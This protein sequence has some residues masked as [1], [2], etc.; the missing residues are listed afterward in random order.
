MKFVAAITVI[1]LTLMMYILSGTLTRSEGTR[2]ELPTGGTEG[3]NTELVAL[4]IMHGHETLAFFDDARYVIDEK[5]QLKE[6]ENQLKERSR[7]KSESV[8]LVMADKKVPTGAL[9]A[10][11]EAAK[12]A[13]MKE[14]L[15]ANRRE[16]LETAE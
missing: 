7:Q 5:T 9:I 3:V 15:V 13:G 1:L 12:R 10:F 8:L 11:T 14:V 2:F 16:N 6:F 4:L